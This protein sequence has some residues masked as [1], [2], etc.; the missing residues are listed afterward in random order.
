MIK[1]GTSGF[2]GII[3]K[4]FTK[5]NISKIAFALSE[6]ISKD[7]VKNPKIA[8]GYDNRLMGKETSTLVANIFSSQGIEVLL[9]T[10][11]VP[12]PLITFMTKKFTYGFM[13]TASHNPANYNGVKIF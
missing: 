6:I 7:K 2:R 9:Y 5:E 3:G 4:G 10:K 1:F 8:V 11:S 13:I 12:S